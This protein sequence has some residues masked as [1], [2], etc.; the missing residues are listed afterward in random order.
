MNS[1]Y[2]LD[3][4]IPPVLTGKSN[5]SL[6]S[7]KTPRCFSLR[8]LHDLLSYSSFSKYLLTS[9]YVYNIVLHTGKDVK[10]YNAHF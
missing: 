5:P 7:F 2:S 10:V 9:N 1:M 3:D 6:S 8:C 4:S